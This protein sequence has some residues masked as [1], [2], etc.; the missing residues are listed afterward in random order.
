MTPPHPSYYTVASV[1]CVFS[2]CRLLPCPWTLLRAL[3]SPSGVMSPLDRRLP[4]EAAGA[5]G[6]G[7][8]DGEV[9]LSTA[10]PEER[11]T[12]RGCS[13]GQMTYSYTSIGLTA[14]NVKTHLSFTQ[15]QQILNDCGNSLSH[16]L[17]VDISNNLV[18]V[19]HDA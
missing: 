7:A 18:V 11:K 3:R 14:N 15:T 2:P 6:V 9:A 10:G 12:G 1:R 4:G 17:S 19:D 16:S 13:H 5:G 8:R